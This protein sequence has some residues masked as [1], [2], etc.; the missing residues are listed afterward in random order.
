MLINGWSGSGGD[1]F[2]YYFRMAGLGPLVGTRT[3]G[4]LIGM[5]GNP[6]PIDGGS[7][8]APTFG[9]YDTDGQWTVE[10]YGVDPDYEVEN[11]PDR[12]VAG[13]DPQLETAIA[14]AL[15]Q[16]EKQPPRRPQKPVY[17][18]RSGR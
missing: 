15:K 5:S 17:P 6:R 14:V 3:W 7:V 18:D 8:S 13:G 4:G 12:M 11:V 1:A 9:I 10:G 16:L 2:P